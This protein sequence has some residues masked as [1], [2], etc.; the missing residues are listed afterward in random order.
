MSADLVPILA[1]D[2]T[3]TL[4]SNRVSAA[5]S[6]TVEELFITR[7][8]DGTIAATTIFPVF[9]APFPLRVLQIGVANFGGALTMDGSNNWS[10]RPRRYR[11][12]SNFATDFVE[13]ISSAGTNFQRQLSALQGEAFWMDE[14]VFDTTV[15]F[16]AN[17]VMAIRVAANGAP[18]NLSQFVVTVR[19]EP[20]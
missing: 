2:V 20:V 17:D 12:T 18:T 3:G 19:V 10:W 11:V 16:R 14:A 13:L 6:P 8:Y 4:R 9:V 7:P 15:K 5:T 1:G